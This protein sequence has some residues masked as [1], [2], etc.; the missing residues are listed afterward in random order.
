MGK[1][2]EVKFNVIIK[3]DFL[4]DFEKIIDHKIDCFLNLSEFPEISS[5]YYA[6]TKVLGDNTVGEVLDSYNE[7]ESNKEEIDFNNPEVNFATHH[8][9]D[10]C[11][12]M[13]GDAR[14]IVRMRP[15]FLG[16]GA[17]YDKNKVK[18]ELLHSVIYR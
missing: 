14:C 5:V 2:V 15:I 12:K 13:V 9:L 7:S 3:D 11:K 6:R 8:T 16:Y 4:E 1:I 10:V 17:N 18:I